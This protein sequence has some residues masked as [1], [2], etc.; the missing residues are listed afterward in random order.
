MPVWRPV[1]RLAGS[2]G[3]PMTQGSLAEAVLVLPLRIE[4]EGGRCWVK[5]AHGRR[6]AQVVEDGMFANYIGEKQ[7]VAQA[8]VEALN[9][10]E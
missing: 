2:R 7:A 6:V 10:E 8:I 3:R 1:H 4:W 9:D 5:N